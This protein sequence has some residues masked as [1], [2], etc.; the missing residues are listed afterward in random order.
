MK[1]GQGRTAARMIEVLKVKELGSSC[2]SEQSTVTA[3]AYWELDMMVLGRC[4][5]AAA[6]EDR[7]VRDSHLKGVYA[8]C[9]DYRLEL[10]E[11]EKNFH[12][13]LLHHGDCRVLDHGHLYCC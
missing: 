3:A 10:L 11:S 9:L 6:T 7:K 13:A 5:L 4:R 12:D 1:A 8:R 2:S